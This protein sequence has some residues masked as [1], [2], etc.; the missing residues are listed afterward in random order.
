M[1]SENH[2]KEKREKKKKKSFWI[3]LLETLPLFKFQWVFPPFS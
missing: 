2:M 1:Y 3:E